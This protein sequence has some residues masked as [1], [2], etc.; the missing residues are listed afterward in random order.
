MKTFPS[1]FLKFAVPNRPLM[2]AGLIALFSVGTPGQLYAGWAWPWQAGS[3]QAQVVQA[4]S[5]QVASEHRA[6]S[7]QKLAVHFGLLSLVLGTVCA[8]VIV[9][10]L[11][12]RTVVKKVVKNEVV[13]KVV[14]EEVIVRSPAHELVADSVVID[15]KNV[16]HGSS[17]D[18]N[19]SLLNLLGLLLELQN[20][21]CAFKCFFDANT[22]Y[23]LKEAGQT[24]AYAYRRLC[25][26]FP[27]L[28]IE[29]PG[30][31]RADDYILDYAHS[32]GA[33]IISNDRYR[34]FQEKYVWLTDARRRVSFV[35]HSG[36]MQIVPL[37]IQAAIPDEL[38]AAESSLRSGL[39]KTP[40]VE[41]PIKSRHQVKH[42]RI[43]GAMVLAR[44]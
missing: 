28:F 40:L 31:N 29:V 21:H 20:R 32:H 35:V 24:E 27:D 30:G 23:T 37:G 5:A 14:R 41:A 6:A 39:A 26:D 9:Y 43:N 44:A 33:P 13:P 36:I 16:L 38:A 22:F 10:H 7:A 15:G 19:P 2:L 3:L 18:Q 25:H 4:R 8:G 1:S 42:A 11:K 34:D 17:A 12:H